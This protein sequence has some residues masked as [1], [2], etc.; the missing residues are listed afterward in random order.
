MSFSKFK[1]DW[2]K[3]EVKIKKA[4]EKA[5]RAAALELFS[6]IILR[7]PVGNPSLWK[8][9][10][11][12]NY[13]GGRLRGNWQATIGSPATDELD[14]TDSSGGKTISAARATVN[15]YTLKQTMY[16][17]NNLP[18]AQVIE[19]GSHTTQPSGM[20]KTSLQDFNQAIKKAA[21][22]HRI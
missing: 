13:V 1:I 20:V 8:S 19:D 22:K 4:S 3:A 17:T 10:A 12:A 21:K 5:V 18:Y 16:L 6:S 7:T 9:P 15:N 14:T 2:D 11:P